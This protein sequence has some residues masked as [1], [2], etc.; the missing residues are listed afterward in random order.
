LGAHRRTDS[1]G[2]TT[3]AAEAMAERLREAG[4]AA[5]DVV[6]LGPNERAGQDFGKL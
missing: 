2:S 3:V 4:C 1:S 5:A 6:V